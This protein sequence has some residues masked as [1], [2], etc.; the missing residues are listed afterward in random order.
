M[1][2]ITLGFPVIV[3]LSAKVFVTAVR[4]GVVK[5]TSESVTGIELQFEDATVASVF[6]ACTL[7]T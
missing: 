1:P 4:V 2:W 6:H 7:F 3:G 5:E